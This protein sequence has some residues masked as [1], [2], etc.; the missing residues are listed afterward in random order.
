MAALAKLDMSD[1]ELERAA[2]DLASILEYF[3]S[4]GAVDTEGIQPAASGAEAPLRPDEPRPSL[5]PAETFANAPDADR[6]S[7][8]FRVPR[9]LGS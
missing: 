9:V 6:A 7:G 2:R 1:A 5:D 3:E 8:V 4:L